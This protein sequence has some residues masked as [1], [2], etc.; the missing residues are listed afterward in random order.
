MTDSMIKFEYIVLSNEA[1]KV[2][3]IKKFIIKLG[4]VSSITD[5]I[6]I[7]C[8]NNRVIAQAKKPLSH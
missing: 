6:E 4:M 3:W 2:I 5:P 8:N 7:Y 1:K